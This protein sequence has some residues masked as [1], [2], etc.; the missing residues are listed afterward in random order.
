MNKVIK[1]KILLEKAVFRVPY[2]MEIIETYP[3]PPYSTVI[4]FIHNMMARSDTIKD[5]NISI[6]GKF[7]NLLREFVRYHKFEEESLRGKPYPVIVTSLIDLEL[8]IHIKMPSEELHNKLFY[9]L[10]NPPFF[11][12]L[13]RPEDLINQME[14]LEECE[15]D[16]DPSTAEKDIL[17]IPY[18]SFIPFEFAKNL[19]IEGISYL[20]PGYYRLKSFRKKGDSE[21]FRDFEMIKVVY[22]QRGQKIDKTIK[23][24]DEEIPIWWM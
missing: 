23:I 22:A 3:L 2:S 16:F 10:Q 20:I 15:K 12:Y 24:D 19:G 7:G 11:P 9:S 8:I 6:Q 17:T 1:V 5:I 13:G 4:G 14:V 21:I 18:D